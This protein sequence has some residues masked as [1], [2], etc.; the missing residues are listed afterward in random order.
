M[1]TMEQPTAH[2]LARAYCVHMHNFP[3]R[4]C[5]S[6][7]PDKS[8]GDHVIPLP[9]GFSC[10]DWLPMTCHLA[11]IVIGCLHHVIW[12][13]NYQRWL[14]RM[15]VIVQVATSLHKCRWDVSATSLKHSLTSS[16][17]S[18]GLLPCGHLPICIMV[19][20]QHHGIKRSVVT[21]NS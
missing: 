21:N 1:S 15:F 8:I 5:T 6:K 17:L 14:F 19:G 13:V 3:Q 9:K 16:G 20:F 18:G 2:K 12:I 7:L 4:T 10:F 11:G